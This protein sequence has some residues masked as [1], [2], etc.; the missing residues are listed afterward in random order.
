MSCNIVIGLNGSEGIGHDSGAALV[1]DGR[2]VAAVEEERLSRSKR[3]FGLPPLLS[4]AEVLS[5]GDIGPGDID[6]IAYPWSPPAM[7][8][9]HAETTALIRS[10][11][12]QVGFVLPTRT[13]VRHIEHHEAHAWTGLAFLPAEATGAKVAVLVVDGTGESTSG[14]AYRFG[15]DLEKIWNLDQ[16]SSLG[17]Y[18]EA[19]SSFIGFE[20]GEEGKAMG[21]AA[22]GRETSLAVPEL[23]DIRFS[24]DIP[25]F[26]QPGETP[27][28]LHEQVRAGHLA[29][30]ETLHGHPGPFNRRADIAHAGQRQL[31]ERIWSYVSELLDAETEYLVLSGGV[32]LNCSANGE[33]ARR[34]RDRGVT[35]VV[36]PPASDTGVAIGAALG[37]AQQFRSDPPVPVDDVGLGR[38]FR[39]DEVV[40]IL[41]DLGLHAKSCGPG[42]VA[43]RLI[44]ESRL[45]GWLEGGSEIGPRALGRR[46]ILARPDSASVRDKVNVLKGRECW[47]PLAPSLSA[48]EFERS[49]RGSVPSPFMLVAAEAASEAEGRLRGVIH[50]DGSARPQVVDRPGP[51][52]DLLTEMGR[53]SGTEAVICTSLN[54]AGEPM[55]YSPFDAV[56]SARRIKLDFL[57]GDGW[58]C[59]LP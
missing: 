16:S 23:T 54:A 39:A 17:I 3:A 5:I 9:S 26:R 18:Y 12:S 32:A 57:A 58:M 19:I 37:V 45:C 29:A 27:R 4:L 21:L 59:E 49:F 34:C 10:W 1:I 48:N 20:W 15:S 41:A 6:V 40:S 8:S 55:V 36:P 44:D 43:A 51:Y 42:D 35:L 38:V 28:T 56:A 53:L 13:E 30:L 7:G 52:A 50:V 11:F 31:V 24:G 25:S 46:A 47:R 14:A 33:F 22:Y 2:V